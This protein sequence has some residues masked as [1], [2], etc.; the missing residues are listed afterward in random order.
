[1]IAFSGLFFYGSH[2]IESTTVSL[3]LYFEHR[4]YLGTAFLFL[5]IVVF[6]YKNVS[7]KVF[8]L[9]SVVFLALLS[10]M[11]FQASRV[12]ASYDSLVFSW[13]EA[14]PESPRAQQQAAMQLL[15][16]GLENEAKAV[17]DTAVS[18]IPDDLN[19]MI[20]KLVVDCKTD[21]VASSS[22]ETVVSL[23]SRTAYDL[24]ALAY[25]QTLIGV[26]KHPGCRKLGWEELSQVVEAL[27][28]V[29][30]N[31]NV[32]SARYAQIQYLLGMIAI[33]THSVAEAEVHFQQSLQSRPSPDAAMNMAAQFASAANFES[34]LVFADKAVK[35]IENGRIGSSGR[36]KDEYLNQIRDFQHTVAVDMAANK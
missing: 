4:N 33:N 11:T 25:Y 8:A 3:E 10:A 12:W 21:S 2:L 16:A 17:T 32:R 1:M 6:I 23:A 30:E 29:R 15:N 18:R 27:L 31:A 14:A 20:W 22:V 26:V 34:A 5:P 9:S 24:R 7:S 13:A 28:R 35:Y 36:S 19:L